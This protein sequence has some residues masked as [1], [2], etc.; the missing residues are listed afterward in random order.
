MLEYFGAA[1]SAAKVA[2]T[3]L[4]TANSGYATKYSVDVAWD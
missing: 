2:D 3:A 4:T 1:R